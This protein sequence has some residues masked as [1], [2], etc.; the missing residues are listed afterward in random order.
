M[1]SGGIPIDGADANRRDAL[2]EKIFRHG[3]H[4]SDS[5]CDRFF[6]KAQRIAPD[7]GELAASTARR[8]T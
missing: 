4:G 5:S 6:A 2:T 1:A 3:L 8:V 7:A